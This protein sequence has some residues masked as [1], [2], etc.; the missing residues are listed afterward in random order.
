MDLQ[1]TVL[2]LGYRT[3]CTYLDPDYYALLVG[4]GILGCFP[5]SKL[6]MNV[7]ERASLA[8]YVNSNLEGT[9]GI[10]TISAGIDGSKRQETR[11]IIEKQLHDLQAGQI[12]EEELE[13]TKRGLISGIAALNDNPA[14]LINRNLIGIV[15][16]EL[17]TVD[18]VIRAI[19][20]VGA[21]DAAEAMNKVVLDTI[22]ILSPEGGDSGG[23]N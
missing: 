17:R 5:H 15:N 20:A 13:Q 4:N 7:R 16:G 14:S 22:Y 9:K 11:K 3:G 12:S 6:F 23:P 1:Q 19:Q 21:Q 2:I 8:Y 10:L 18:Q